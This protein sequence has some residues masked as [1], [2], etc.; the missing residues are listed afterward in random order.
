MKRLWVVAIALLLT[1][2]TPV[3]TSATPSATPA[4]SAAASPA[5]TDTTTEPASPTDT[6]PPPAT[7]PAAPVNPTPGALSL[8]DPYYPNDGNDGYRVDNYS[9]DLTYTPG[10]DQLAGTATITADATQDLSA[11]SFDFAL[12]ASGATVNG[13]PAR[14]AAA[15][16]KLTIT[17]ATAIG[18]GQ[19]MVVT[20]TYAGV[21]SS[22]RLG[23][24]QVWFKLKNGSG[25]GSVA[26]PYYASAWYPCNDEPSQKATFD[27]AMSVPDGTSAISNGALVSSD[28]ANGRTVWR[29]HLAQPTTTYGTMIAIG[30][31]TV[32][33][34][35]TPDGKPFIRAYD[36]GLSATEL[37]NAQA[38]I[39][40]TPEIVAW[41]QSMYG[42]YPFDVLGGVAIDTKPSQD[43][44]EEY[45][46]RPVYSDN[47][48]SDDIT[49]VVHENSHEWFGDAVS[50]RTWRD[51]WLNEGFANYTEWLWDEHTGK[52][53]AAQDADKDYAG[54]SASNKFWQ[55][56]PADP[57]AKNL[58]A[59]PVYE[60]GAMTL[61]AL[62]STVGDAVFFQILQHRVADNLYGSESTAEFIA[63]AEKISGRNLDALFNTWLFTTG[64]PPNPPS[65]P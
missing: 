34:T 18:N 9:L 47:F 62:R 30:K 32:Q 2:C 48:G 37:K 19:R 57:G 4:P 59:D 51:I 35:L 56:K 39:E 61:Q 8:G 26:E 27:V 36:Q 41:E 6:P 12:P 52:A 38:D 33:N 1:A 53:T 17:P 10:A 11:F 5:P 29:W 24:E 14:I 22:V 21:P 49:D 15:N 25:A 23:G 16:N 28:S 63:L 3:T 31:F 46:S 43:D 58:L 54:Y 7:T 40:R 20:V 64:R 50:P 42:P 13:A 55:I 45:Q 60:R 65:H 44:A